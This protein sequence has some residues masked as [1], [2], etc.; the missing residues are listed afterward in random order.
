[1]I[2]LSKLVDAIAFAFLV[3]CDS[4]FLL[5]NVKPGKIHSIIYA[6]DP[7]EATKSKNGAPSSNTKDLSRRELMG[8]IVLSSIAIG[9]ILQ[10]RGSHVNAEVFVDPDRYGDKELKIGLVG[11]LKQRLRNEILRNPTLADD[12][13]RLAII[14]ALS[15][16]ASTKKGGLNGSTALAFGKESKD[17]Q[18]QSALASLLKVKTGLPKPF[19]MSS[20]G[21]VT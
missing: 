12:F 2:L 17:G 11:S 10:L 9:G 20:Y 14:D 6:G 3:V 4:F 8:D 15:F 5:R 13:L 16:D 7:S 1:M 18:I 19:R 21:R